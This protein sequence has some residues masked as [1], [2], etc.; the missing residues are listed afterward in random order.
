MQVIE[1]SNLFYKV[2]NEKVTKLESVESFLI[3]LKLKDRIMADYVT[4]E[5][6]VIQHF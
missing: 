3:T 4:I 6:F 2:Y 5:K 1:D